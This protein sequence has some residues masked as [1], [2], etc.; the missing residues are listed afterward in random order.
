[1]QSP[2]LPCYHVPLKPKYLPQHPLFEHF[3]PEVFH[4]HDR[5]R[6]TPTHKSGNTLVLRRLVAGVSCVQSALYLFMQSFLMMEAAG[7]SETLAPILTA[8][9]HYRQGA[10]LT[11]IALLAVSCVINWRSGIKLLTGVREA[12]GDMGF[13]VGCARDI[14]WGTSLKC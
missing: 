12:S 6:F 1:M 11:V 3:Q 7:S 4:Q 13:C 10:V 9:C 14:Q 5:P 8:Q 2:P